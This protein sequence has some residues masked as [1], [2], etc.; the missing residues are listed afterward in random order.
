M[1]MKKNARNACADVLTKASKNLYNAY[2]K[3]HYIN[4]HKNMVVAYV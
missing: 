4:L 3:N 2:E 1:K